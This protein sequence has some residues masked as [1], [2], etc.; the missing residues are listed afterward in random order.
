MQY[1]CM[2]ESYIIPTSEMYLH[3]PNRKKFSRFHGSNGND[4]PTDLINNFL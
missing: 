1:A 2:N 3:P 4:N